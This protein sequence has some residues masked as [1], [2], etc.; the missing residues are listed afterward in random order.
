ME[1]DIKGYLDSYS[2]PKTTEAVLAKAVVQMADPT[3]ISGYPD[4]INSAINLYNKP[5]LSGIGDLMMETIGALPLMG[6]LALPYKA[7]KAAKLLNKLGDVSKTTKVIDNINSVNKKIDTFSELIPG[8]RKSAEITQD[9]TSKY[10]TTPIF[11]KVASPNKYLKM[12]QYRIGNVGIDVVNTTGTVS[13]GY[14][15]VSQ[16]KDILTNK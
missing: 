1:P 7:A 2:N 9:L 5:S 3:G 8:V 6:K 10:L 11:N 4:V 12:R 13:D 16:T 14:Q 15:G